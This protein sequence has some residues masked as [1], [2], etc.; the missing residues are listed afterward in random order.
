MVK[1]TI[2]LILSALMF[3]VPA[4]A[5]TVNIKDALN[6]E[7]TIEG[8]AEENSVVSVTV[9]NEGYEMADITDSSK[10]A[11]QFYGFTKA[12]DGTYKIDVKLLDNAENENGGGVFKIIVSNET[13]PTLYEFYFSD[14]KIEQMGKINKV[15]PDVYKKD[16][17]AILKTFSLE[18]GEISNIEDGELVKYIEKQKDSAGNISDDVDEFYKK[19]KI[20]LCLAA[21]NSGESSLFN[22][23]SISFDDILGI[24]GTEYYSDY[25]LGLTD[26]GKAAVNNDI[27]KK[28][29]KKPSEI[30]DDF[31]ESVALNLVV[32]NKTMGY[33][34][35][36]EVLEKYSDIFAEYNIYAS[37]INKM[38][39]KNAVYS[40]MSLS[41]AKSLTQ[42]YKVVKKFEKSKPAGQSS[43]GNTGGTTSGGGSARPS[44]P[45]ANQNVNEYIKPET[46]E[47]DKETKLPFD[48]ISGFEWAKDYISELY[49]EGVINGKSKTKFEPSAFITRGEFTK[50]VY[51][52]FFGTPPEGECKFS[53]VNDF[54][55]N[56][57]SAA[58]DMGI[59]MGKGENRFYPGSQITREE[60]GAVLLRIMEKYGIALEE[61]EEA[62]ADDKDISD[63]GK[64]AVYVLKK[65]GIISGRGDNKFYPKESLN[66]AETVKIICETRKYAN[67]EK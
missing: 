41:N 27:I 18:L 39:N 20:A 8:K 7:I 31:N 42:L 22:T 3:S 15:S 17:R 13:T 50:I 11:L 30:A 52:A 2:S 43:G 66:R 46:T 21:F 9:L 6:D 48:D 62:F 58:S 33:G 24:A 29:Y 67:A 49:G 16:L 12:V 36:E 38:S 65:A 55:K 59:I 32:N 37:K 5:A 47:N 14:K 45:S 26:K 54:S 25:F 19:V 40:A 63:W 57:V 4:G 10:K 44:V 53:D 64:K 28:D 61:S 60:A 1:K 51:G 35:I 56:Y 23:D 34:H